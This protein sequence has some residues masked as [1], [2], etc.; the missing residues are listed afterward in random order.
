MIL[1][2]LSLIGIGVGALGTLIGAGGGFLVVPLLIMA[3]GAEPAMAA[4]TSMV[5]VTINSLVGTVAYARQGKVDWRGG[6]F[7]SAAAYPGTLLGAWVGTRLPARQFSLIFGVLLLLLAGWMIYQSLRKASAPRALAAAAEGGDA[8]GGDAEDADPVPAEP[9]IPHGWRFCR[10]LVEIGGPVHAYCFAMPL[11]ALLSFVIGFLGAMMGIGGG[12]LLVPA[13]IYALHYPPHIATA[14]SQFIKALTSVG[15]AAVY[16]LSGKILVDQAIV[17][18]LGTVVGAPFGA[19]LSK[20]TNARQLVL[21]LAVVLL[22]LSTR[23]LAA[24]PATH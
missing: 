17:L 22:F 10:H 18:S 14:T 3:F 21:I 11:G 9:A 5:M 16:L 4:G 13:M 6:L 15:A 2:L 24:G 1:A 7:L 23:L 8:E 12:P 19:W 20:R